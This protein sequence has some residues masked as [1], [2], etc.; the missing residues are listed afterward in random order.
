LALCTSALCLLLS[1]EWEGS[2]EQK[3]AAMRGVSGDEPVWN[4]HSLQPWIFKDDHLGNFL[5]PLWLR[6]R[7]IYAE[8][9]SNLAMNLARMVGCENPT[10]GLSRAIVTLMSHEIRELEEEGSSAGS[11]ALTAMARPK[12]SVGSCLP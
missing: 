1:A 5:V 8:K 10:Q 4:I 6:L 2:I 7:D 3:D 11:G 9:K 12:G